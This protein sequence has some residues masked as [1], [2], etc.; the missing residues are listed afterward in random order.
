MPA[1]R[2]MSDSSVRT[3]HS[4]ATD[5]QALFPGQCKPPLNAETCVFQRSSDQ[6]S[7]RVFIAGATGYIGKFVTRELV[8]RKYDV[9]SFARKRSGIDGSTTAGE[10]CRQLQGSEV[11]FG[12]VCD[13]KSLFASGIRHEQFDAVV[14]CL[15]SRTGGIR[16]SW[17]IDYQANRNILEAAKTSGAQHFVLLSAICVQKPLL[18][19]QKA[20]LQFE[21]ELMNSGM[22]YSIV[23]PTAFFKSLAGQVDALK[24]G[25]PYIMFGNGDLTSCKPISEADLARFMAD[26]LEIPAKKNRILPIGGPGEPISAKEQGELLFELMGKKP[27]FK[28]IPVRVFD[29]VIP[30]LRMLAKVLPSVADKA[31]FARIGHY[32]ATE[33]ML[34]LNPLTGMYDGAATPSYGNDTLREFY[35][36]ILKEGCSGQELGA[37]SIFH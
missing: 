24:K 14:S 11:R 7:K 28:K 18:E 2:T 26:C 12:N 23:R 36:R 15:T 33:S 16:D 4:Y 22:T 6:Q 1:N 13:R 21:K 5:R 34:V 27:D 37:H 30:V 31:E 3:E 20:K 17:L 9:V 25:K 19:F 8:A 29:L 35:K 10:T 32:Y